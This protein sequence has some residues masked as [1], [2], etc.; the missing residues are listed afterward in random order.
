MITASDRG[1]LLHPARCLQVFKAT[2]QEMHPSD[3][4]LKEHLD[5]PSPMFDLM[6]VEDVLPDEVL[7]R[8]LLAAEQQ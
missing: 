5:A 2:F 3:A 6:G 1:L 8:Y 4:L 7:G